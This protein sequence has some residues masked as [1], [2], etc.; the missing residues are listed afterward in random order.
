LGKLHCQAFPTRT[1]L[2]FY[3]KP[4]IFFLPCFASFSWGDAGVLGCLGFIP[5]RTNP[6]ESDPQQLAPLSEQW[7][8]LQPASCVGD[9]DPGQPVTKLQF[10]GLS[11]TFLPNLSY[12]Y[13]LVNKFTGSQY[14]YKN[15]QRLFEYELQLKRK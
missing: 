5:P 15:L 7:L 6:S 3:L 14:K 1:I 11:D 9:P 8:E 13:I 2:S 10:S 4:L 12:I